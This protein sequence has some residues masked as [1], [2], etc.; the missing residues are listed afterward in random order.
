MFNPEH[1][2]FNFEHMPR[3]PNGFRRSRE[4]LYC[5]SAEF[6]KDDK[7]V[8]LTGG[9]GAGG[10]LTSMPGITTP[11]PLPRP[12]LPELDGVLLFPSRLPAT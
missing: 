7:A 12:P 3:N 2:R 4:G 5:Q 6:P 9:G 1:A 10:L 8:A 11:P